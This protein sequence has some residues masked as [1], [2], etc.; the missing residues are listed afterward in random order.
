MIVYD[1]LYDNTYHDTLY[2]SSWYNYLYDILCADLT[3][4]GYPETPL[5]CDV[6]VVSGVALYT[7][8]A[9]YTRE[10]QGERHCQ[11]DGTWSGSPPSCTVSVGG[12]VDCTD[13]VSPTH[14]Y[15]LLSNHR[16]LALYRCNQGYTLQGDRS[17]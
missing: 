9:G 2:N 8:H 7:C 3:D 12:G 14:G 4:C 5:H 13:P 10:G 1:T 15:T 16:S 11:Y 17:R 6:S